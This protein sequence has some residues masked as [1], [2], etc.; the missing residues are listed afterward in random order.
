MVIKHLE[1]WLNNLKSVSETTS[2][3]CL[4][5]FTKIFHRLAMLIKNFSGSINNRIRPDT[6]VMVTKVILGYKQITANVFNHDV[7]YWKNKHLL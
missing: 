4:C 7:L 3:I 2:R 1:Y 6:Q 5:N